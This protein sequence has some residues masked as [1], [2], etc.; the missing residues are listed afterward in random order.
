MYSQETIN[1]G[2]QTVI[3]HKPSCTKQTLPRLNKIKL[4]TLFL[5]GYAIRLIIIPPLLFRDSLLLP[6]L[7][8]LAGL[9]NSPKQSR[10]IQVLI[11]RKLLVS[12]FSGYLHCVSNSTALLASRPV[13]SFLDFGF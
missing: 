6:N 8:L 11:L 2:M 1:C 12:I 9:F 13:T 7:K 5:P 3:A 10:P 4:G